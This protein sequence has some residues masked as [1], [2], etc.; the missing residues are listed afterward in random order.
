MLTILALNGQLPLSALTNIFFFLLLN[1]LPF[2][3]EDEA[4]VFVVVLVDF[5]A[6]VV[7]LP[8]ED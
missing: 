5:A 1:G 3:P 7:E 8:L 2:L 4:D 6:L